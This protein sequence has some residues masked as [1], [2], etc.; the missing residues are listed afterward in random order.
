MKD[1]DLRKLKKTPRSNYTHHLQHQDPAAPWMPPPPWTPA[2][3]CCGRRPP[4]LSWTPTAIAALPPAATMDLDR[5]PP[6][7]MEAEQA[8]T[9]IPPRRPPLLP[10]STHRR[11]AGAEADGASGGDGRSR[12]EEMVGDGGG[13]RWLAMSMVVANL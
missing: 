12:G 5:A 3:C 7:S 8:R 10:S 6:A 4:L 2:A 9:I 13:K 1:L 11:L